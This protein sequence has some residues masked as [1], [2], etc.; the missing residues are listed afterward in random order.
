MKRTQHI[1]L[2]SGMHKKA[3]PFP[4]ADANGNAV[5]FIDEAGNVQAHYVYDAF[6]NTVSQTGAMAAVFRFLFSSKYLDDETA[7]YFYGFRYYSPALGR[8][9]SRDPV[10][11][12]GGLN[13]FGYVANNV[14][15]EYDYL[16]MWCDPYDYSGTECPPDPPAEDEDL[17]CC[18]GKEYQPATHCC[19]NAGAVEENGGAGSDILSR[20]KV[21]TG[22]KYC[23]EVF[24]FGNGRGGLLRHAWIE[25]PGGIAAGF[26]S[27][28]GTPYEIGRVEDP[29]DA[30]ITGKKKKCFPVMLSPCEYNISKFVQAVLDSIKED[31]QDPPDFGI[32]GPGY[33]CQEWA[34][35]TISGAQSDAGGCGV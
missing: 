31:K 28:C 24:G 22:I 29:D 10:D 21:D 17:P 23:R 33:N 14:V 30:V 34:K 32:I 2:G 9:M 12:E 19:C 4:L 13:V 1:N 11:E 7:L 26:R 18:D 5:S 25:G 8:W 6:G 20:E 35:T 27:K 15:G 16:G 3:T